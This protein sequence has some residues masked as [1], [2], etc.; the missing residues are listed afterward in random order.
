MSYISNIFI[1]VFIPDIYGVSRHELIITFNTVVS[2]VKLN[3]TQ[4]LM[5][6]FKFIVI[7]RELVCLGYS[8]A[9]HLLLLQWDDLPAFDEDVSDESGVFARVAQDPSLECQE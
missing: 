1:L 7:G 9:R 2:L 6:A 5:L 4:H 8:S 3:V